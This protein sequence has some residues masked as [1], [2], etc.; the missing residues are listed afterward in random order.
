MDFALIGLARLAF[1]SHHKIASGAHSES[2][3][4]VRDVF[5]RCLRRDVERLSDIFGIQPECE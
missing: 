1:E 5:A 2:T 3:H 4:C